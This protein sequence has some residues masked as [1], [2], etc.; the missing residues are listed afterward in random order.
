MQGD[1][2]NR[3]ARRRGLR[4]KMQGMAALPES[5]NPFKPGTG[6]WPP[7]LAGR[8]QE[9]E[10]IRET[11]AI[12]KSKR[13]QDGG[14]LQEAPLPPIKLVGP[15]GA[16]KTTLLTYADDE[17]E[18]QEIHVVRCASLKDKKGIDG[19]ASFIELMLGDF[20]IGGDFSARLGLKNYAE[21][22]AS[23]H[24]EKRETY[25]KVVRGLLAEKAV[26]FLLDE[27]IH[28]DKDLLAMLLQMNQQLMSKRWPLAMIIAG[29]PGLDSFLSAVDATFINRSHQ[30]YIHQ[31]SDEATREA[32]GKPFADNGCQISDDALELMASWTDNYPYFIQIAGKAV[33]KAMIDA[34]RAEVDKALAQA[35]EPA[36]QDMRDIYY[37]SLY[38]DLTEAKLLRYANHMVGIVENA[39][40]PPVLQQACRQLEQATGI[41][42]DSSYEICKQMQDL[43]LLWVAKDRRVEAAIPS[44]F[45][46]FKKAYAEDMKGEG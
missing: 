34:K 10:V 44:F 11:L 45:S 36:M 2:F 4:G 8:D 19:L 35:A 14:P 46:Y 16:G 29:T 26:L 42:A 32:L 31:L 24:V 23:A 22:K 38:L 25:D 43:N 30:M 7:V 13:K 41:D 40:K 20:E 28:Y 12:I 27:A 3:R 37:Q 33:W 1:Y 6:S 21:I 5:N 18:R 9:T 15:R 17:A 39:K